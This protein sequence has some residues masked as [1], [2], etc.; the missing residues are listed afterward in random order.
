MPRLS[1][2]EYLL[3]RL[4]ECGIDTLFG[5]PGDFNLSLLEQVVAAPNLEW[6]GNCNELNAAYAADGYARIKGAGCLVVTYGVGDLSALNGIAGSFAEHVP[7]ICVSGIP[8]THALRLRSMLHHTSG[9]GNFEDILSCLAQFTAAQA[10]LTP[11]NAATEIDR[12]I[13]TAMREKLPVYV[14][15]PSDITHIEINA[16][17]EP[18]DWSV[19]GDS[20]RTSSVIELIAARIDQAERPALLVDA[21][22]QRFGLGTLIRELGE[23]AGIPFATMSSGRS[24]LDEQ[25][26][27]YRGIYVGSVSAPA[28]VATIEESDCLIAIGVRFFDINTTVFSHTL[29]ES[30]MVILDPFSVSLDEQTIEGIEAKEI[31]QGLVNLYRQ[32]TNKRN[33]KQEAHSEPLLSSNTKHAVDAPLTH[34]TLWPL[35]ADFLSPD[36]LMLVENGTAQPGI[37]SIRLPENTH[38]ISQSVW[39]SIGYTL[40]ALLGCMMARSEGRS[41]LFIGDGS[42]QMTVQEISTML[43]KKLKPIIFVLNNGGYTIERVILGADSSYNDIA[44]WNYTALP[45]AFSQNCAVRT[46]SVRT[47]AELQEALQGSA[48]PEALTLIELHLGSMDAPKSLISMGRR[49]AEYDFDARVLPALANVSSKD[50]Q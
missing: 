34:A 21:D 46:W 39:A 28:T 47:V 5:V 30:K 44:P 45:A 20:A 32:R 14:Q 37:A 27:L 40:P 35:I 24:I 8:P 12:V 36:D 6:V 1:I 2:G 16:S 48:Q 49:V 41:L 38:F 3:A 25:H 11:T 17:M 10:R 4:S 29:D 7:V 31:L 43:S 18:L 19:Y 22:A 26:P 15:I 9:T 23:S 33:L 13:T 50:A 42:L